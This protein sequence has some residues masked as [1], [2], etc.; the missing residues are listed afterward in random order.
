[1]IRGGGEGGRGGGG[2][3]GEE[4]GRGGRREG[5]R[6][7]GGGGRRGEGGEKGRERR[8][9]EGGGEG[10]GGGG[11][12]AGT[13]SLSSVA[14]TYLG[15]EC[16]GRRCW[17]VATDSLAVGP[18]ESAVDPSGSCSASVLAEAEPGADPNR[19]A[20]D[21]RRPVRSSGRSRRPGTLSQ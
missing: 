3:R 13:G 21:S 9:G 11:P 7:E 19:D 5:G 15:Q 10:G 16:G 20:D 6:R 1:M 8:G 4:G 17:L 14:E 12:I 18:P 2:K